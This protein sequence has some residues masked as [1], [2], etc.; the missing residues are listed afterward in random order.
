MDASEFKRTVKDLPISGNVDNPEGALDALLQVMACKSKLG[1]RE[2]SR[3]IV[4]VATDRDYHNAMDGKLG[5]RTL[6]HWIFI[7]QILI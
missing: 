5:W 6:A 4:L 7:G 2:S 3:K 1:W